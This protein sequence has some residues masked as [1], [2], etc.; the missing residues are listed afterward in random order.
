MLEYLHLTSTGTD[1]ALFVQQVLLHGHNA[2]AFNAE[3]SE[4][5]VGSVTDIS[6]MFRAMHSNMTLLL[7]AFPSP[8]VRY[9]SQSQHTTQTD[10][11]L[12][13]WYST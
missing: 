10:L 6:D 8:Y 11:P 9:L 5:N 2:G 12:I 1:T 7:L 4:W 3:L 13:Q